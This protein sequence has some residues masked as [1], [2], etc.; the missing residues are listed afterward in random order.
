MAFTYINIGKYALDCTGF[1]LR[2]ALILTNAM[3][4][5][6]FT[7]E[8]ITPGPQVIN[9]GTYAAGINP[10]DFTTNAIVPGDNALTF[11]T[12]MN[13]NFTTLFAAIGQPTLRG[14]IL[15]GG[16]VGMII[17]ENSPIIGTGDPGRTIWYKVNENFRY[18]YAVI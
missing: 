1:N 10:A 18:L 12:K 16:E 17:G 3:F 14:A 4:A 2:Q 11:C 5:E 13:A 8:G 7:L 6:L 9:I 15:L